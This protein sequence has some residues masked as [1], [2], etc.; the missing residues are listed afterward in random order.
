MEKSITKLSEKMDI[1][2]RKPN[3][4]LEKVAIGVITAIVMLVISLALR[5]K[6]VM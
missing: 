6:G 1:I 3:V 2:D 5:A 4:L